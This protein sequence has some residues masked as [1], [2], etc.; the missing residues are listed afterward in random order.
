MGFEGDNNNMQFCWTKRLKMMQLKCLKN[1]SSGNSLGIA[2][3]VG[4]S[5]VKKK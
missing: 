1:G 3:L 5:G 4:Q 2:S